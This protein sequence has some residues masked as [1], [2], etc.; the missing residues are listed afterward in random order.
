MGHRRNRPIPD[1]IKLSRDGWLICQQCGRET[2]IL[3][4]RDDENSCYRCLQGYEQ[5]SVP[6]DAERDGGAR[7]TTDKF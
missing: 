6:S 2:W 1:S 3:F 5:S 7:V 4:P